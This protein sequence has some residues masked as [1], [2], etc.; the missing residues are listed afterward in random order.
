MSQTPSTGPTT[1]DLN[2]WIETLKKCE[3]IKDAD[4]KSLCN[5]AKEILEKESNVQ[6][7]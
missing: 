5:K 7:V 1:H 4:V 3:Y 6:H 2:Q